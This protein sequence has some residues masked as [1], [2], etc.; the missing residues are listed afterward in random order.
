MKKRH[1]RVSQYTHCK[2]CQHYK[3]PYHK[4]WYEH[5]PKP[6]FETES[7]TIFWD[8]TIHADRKSDARKPDIFIKDYKNKSCLLVKLMF[9]MDKNLWRIWK[10]I[11]I[12]GPGN[13]NRTN[14]ATKTDTDTC[15]YESSWYSKKRYKQIFTINPW[16]KYKRNPE[17]CTNKHNIYS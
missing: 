5:K 6:V 14:V 12:P 15:S 7:A 16:K 9:P 8:F 13:R 3:A 1:D 4:N 17:N 2:I 10:N 11:K